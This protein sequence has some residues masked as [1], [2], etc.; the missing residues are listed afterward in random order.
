MERRDRWSKKAPTAS[1]ERTVAR[2]GSPRWLHG[3]S[4]SITELSA[5]SLSAD[6]G[7]QA[8]LVGHTDWLKVR[9]EMLRQDLA[10]KSPQH[11][12][13]QKCPHAAVG[14]VQG[15]EASDPETLKYDGRDGGVGKPTGGA[16]QQ[17]RVLLVVQED[18]EARGWSGRKCSM[19]S[20]KG[21]YGTGGRRAGYIGVAG[22]ERLSSERA[23]R[24]RERP[25]VDEPERRRWFHR[26]L[27][28]PGAEVRRAV[29]QSIHWPETA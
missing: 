12:A 24:R 14:L 20:A 22:R 3:A 4:R 13:N 27:A 18:A 7:A 1:T 29:V 8:V 16:I 26:G 28:G 2:G 19:A 15:Y 10:N 5:N 21:A 11:V 23:S 17:A 25:E 6:P 9:R